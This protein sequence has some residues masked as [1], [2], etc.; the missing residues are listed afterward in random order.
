MFLRSAAFNVAFF[1]WTTLY[2]VAFMPALVMPRRAVLLVIRGWAGGVAWLLEHIVGLTSATR[3]VEHVPDGAAVVA[4]KHQSAWDTIMFPRLLPDPVYVLK[5]E[6]FY[7]PVFGWYAWRAGS[8]VV[9]RKGGAKAL[10][11]MI[12]DARAALAE[13]RQVV[14]FPEGTR[15]APGRRRPYQ[16]GIAA[17][18]AQLGAPVVPVALNS[19]LFWGRRSFVKRPGRVVVQFLPPILP[20]LDRE[21]F[22]AELEE[23]IET[24]CG[25]LASGELV[26]KPVDK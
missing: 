20:G 11:R 10:K 18:Y 23:R 8:I 26:D 25:A 16:P 7:I 9:D 21:R 24:A 12:G 22:M 1:A 15:V 6:I 5:R 4:S 3:G 14:V 17:F 2:S 19:G 13:G